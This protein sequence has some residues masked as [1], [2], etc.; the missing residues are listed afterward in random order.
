MLITFSFWQK[1]RI[2]KPFISVEEFEKFEEDCIKIP[3][4]ETFTNTPL[5]KSKVK[6]GINERGERFDSKWEFIAATYFREIEGKVVERNRTEFVIYIDE[7]N[8]QRKWFWDLT[9]AG[10]KYE[11]KGIFREKDYQKQI[12]HPEIKFLINDDI[13]R[14]VSELDKKIGKGWR[15]NFTELI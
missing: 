11:I 3:K 8:I 5:K 12:Q 2:I 6:K 9:V 7:K 13:K 1:T 4:L 15:N 10:E 14:M